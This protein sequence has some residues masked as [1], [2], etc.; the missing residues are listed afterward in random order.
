MLEIRLTANAEHASRDRII[1]MR[2]TA[3]PWCVGAVMSLAAASTSYPLLNI[4]WTMFLFF[5]WV[6]WIGLLIM[7]FIDIFRSHDLSGAAKALWVLFVFLVPLIGAVAYLIVRGGDMYQRGDRKAVP[8]DENVLSSL[9]ASPGPSASTADQLQK[10]AD[11]RDRG[12]ITAA[13]FDREK[14]KILA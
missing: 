1:A 10:L 13:E 6:S 4:F 3:T 7:V 5:V 14:A 8:Y 12:A 9:Q 2:Q 11:V